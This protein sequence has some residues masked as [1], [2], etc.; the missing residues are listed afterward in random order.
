MRQDKNGLVY[1]AMMM[2]TGARRASEIPSQVIELHNRGQLETVNLTE[3][4]AVDH[5]KPRH[6][7]HPLMLQSKL[8]NA[9]P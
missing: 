9:P 3:W 1:E 6:D 7:R 8:S 2:R 4:L 5:E